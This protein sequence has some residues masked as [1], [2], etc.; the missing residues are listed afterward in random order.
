MRIYLDNSATTKPYP[1]VVAAMQEVLEANWG[2]PS[3]IHSFGRDAFDAMSRAREQ[4]AGLIGAE[5]GEIYFTSGGTEADNLALLGVAGRFE[6]GHIITSAIEHA[7]VLNSCRHLEARGFQV[8]YLPPD[9]AGCLCAAQVEQALRPDTL[10]VSVMLANNEIGSIQ[11]VAELGRLLADRGVLLHTDAVQAVGKMPVDVEALGVDMLTLS[12]HKIN[13]PKGIGAL[14]V[15]HGVEME[16]RLWGGGQERGLR[17]GTENLPGIVGLGEAARLT[18]ERWPAQVEQAAAARQSFWQRL[19]QLTG[20]FVLNGGR[21]QRLPNNLNLSF[22][23]VDGA[24]LLLFLDMAGVAVSA[25]SACSSG[26]AEPSHV[27]QALGLED[28]RLKSAVRL[29]F[30]W[31]NTPEEGERAAEIFAEQ[32]RWL[33]QEAAPE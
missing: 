26:R 22:A 6:R 7:A 33:R 15:R 5:P 32:L 23:G 24:A 14:Y 30:G 1:E 10:L 18:G 21:E 17:S 11:P 3:G 31:E 2:N 8:T 25:A 16:P 20:G 4:V 9:E 12:G 13:G 19:S 29:S 27:L 28:W